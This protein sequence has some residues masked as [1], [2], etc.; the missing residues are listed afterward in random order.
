MCLCVYVCITGALF[1]WLFEGTC[2]PRVHPKVRFSLFP[3][4][5]WA[6]APKNGRQVGFGRLVAGR[7]SAHIAGRRGRRG[8]D[9]A[10]RREPQLGAADLKAGKGKDQNPVDLQG[11]PPK[12]V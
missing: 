10:S 8:P 9:S 1:G 6:P 12:V 2:V 3:I 5:G 7:H 4:L 11:C